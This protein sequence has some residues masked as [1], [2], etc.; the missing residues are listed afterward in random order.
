MV[1]LIDHKAGK[2]SL[3]ELVRDNRAA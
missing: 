2:A 3:G 1:A